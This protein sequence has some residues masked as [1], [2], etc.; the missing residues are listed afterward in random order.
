MMQYNVEQMLF[1]LTLTSSGLTDQ[2]EA[3]TGLTKAHRG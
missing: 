2:P 1:Q 3:N